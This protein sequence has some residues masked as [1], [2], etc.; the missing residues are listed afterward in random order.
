VVNLLNLLIG[1]ARGRVPGQLVIQLTDRCNGLCPQCGM[2][3]SEAYPRRRLPVDRVKGIIDAAAARG[4]S[5]LSF[6]GGEPLLLLPDLL[7]LIRYAGRAGI[8]Y[9]RTGTNGF[10]F[11]GADRPGFPG[12]IARL[13]DALAATPLRNFWISLD[14]ADP[15]V[16]EAMRGFA[17]VIAG[18]EKALPIFH[19]RGLYPTANLG[20]NRNLAGPLD[21]S[22]FLAAVEGRRADPAGFYEYYRS[23]FR[24]FFDFVIDLGFTMAGCCY[25]IAFGEAGEPGELRAVYGA[26]S[27]SPVV[28]FSPEEKALL[29]SALSD[30][31]P[32]YRNRLRLVTPRSALHTLIG[33]VRGEDRVSY[34]CRGGI[35]FLF[36]GARDGSVYPC[37]YRGEEPLGNLEDG[38]KDR[39]R[40]KAACR[41]CE[42]ECFRDPSVLFGP[43]LE[44]FRHPLRLGR[45]LARDKNFYRL[46]LEDVA[47]YRVCRLFNGR[48]AP[49]PAVRREGHEQE[50]ARPCG[51]A[52]E[53]DLRI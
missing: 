39:S 37:G 38:K 52:I 2:R 41:Q 24:S 21:R 46:W 20:L 40:A 48:L 25:P 10:M 32:E 49:R 3:V 19:G 6:T 51:Q 12:R 30:T 43:T 27:T 31:L 15:A 23:G 8:E 14:S 44:L 5:I 33:E 47:Y 26:H 45:R 9:I 7:E 35:D 17:G 16:H 18:I 29:F 42:W 53:M 11:T 22:P 4:V 28:R 13:A 36:V 34:P 50:A 1:L